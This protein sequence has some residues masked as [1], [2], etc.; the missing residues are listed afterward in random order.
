MSETTNGGC[1][2]AE[3][4]PTLSERFWRAMG[5]KRA[6]VHAPNFMEEVEG[7]VSGSI[8]TNVI[9]HMGWLDRLR[10]LVSGKM[11]VALATMTNVTVDRA[12]TVSECGVLPPGEH[13]P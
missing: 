6:Y 12:V 2:Y 8:T 11:I 10:L 9:C 7:F 4:K 3:Y 13:K 5:F 1:F